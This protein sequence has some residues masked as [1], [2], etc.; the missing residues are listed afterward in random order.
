MKL[1]K[2]IKPIIIILLIVIAF[3]FVFDNPF[4]QS[5]YD[6]WNEEITDTMY[7]DALNVIKGSSDYI[8]RYSY[9]SFLEEFQIQYGLED[10]DATLL[11]AAAT[12]NFDYQGN[13]AIDLEEAN[14]VNYQVSIDQAGLYYIYV[15]YYV[16][17]S[18]LNNLTISVKINDEIE[19]DDAQIVDVPLIWED[20]SKEFSLDTYGDESLPNQLRVLEWK[21]LPLYNNTYTTT[22]PLLFYFEEG[23][24]TITFENVISGAVLFGD[25]QVVSPKVVPSYEAYST[26]YVSENHPET[27]LNIDATEYVDKNS[28]Y[29]RLYSFQSP[30]VSPFDSIDKKLNVINGAAWYRSG[31]EVTYS[32]TVSETGLYHLNL[33]YLNDKD[34]FSVFRSIYIDGEIPFDAFESYEFKVTGQNTWANEV[35]GTDET[36]FD[37]YLEEGV[38]QIAFRVETDSLSEELRNIQL[39]VDHINAFALNILKITGVNIDADR[40]WQFTNYIPETE[41]YL[42]AYETI[43]KR[44]VVTLSKYSNQ[45]DL[46]ATLAYLKTAVSALEVIVEEPDKIPLYLDSLYSG[47]GSVTQMLG[48]SL[49]MISKQPLYL[50]GFTIYNDNELDSPNA[51]FIQKLGSGIR[52]FTASFTEKKY[53]TENNPEAVNIWVSRSLIYVDLMQK[54]ADKAFSGTDIQIKI[55]IMPDANKLILAN[56]ANQTPDVALGLPSYMPFDLAIRG[57]LQDLSEFSDFWEVASEFS[58]GAF[59]P[60]VL[61]D[62]VYAI[63]ETLEFHALAYRIDTMNALGLS[64]PSTWEDVIDMLPTLQRYGMNFFYPTSGGTS[65]KWFYQTSALIYQSGGSIYNEDGLSTSINSEQSYNGLKLL[66]DLYTTYSL[67]SYVA[68]F[69]NSFRYNTL[70]IGIIDFNTYLTLKNAAPELTG[71][72]ALALY[73]GIEDENGDVQRW[74][75]ANGTSAIMFKNEDTQKLS[76][77][78]EFMKWWL[79]T[80]TQTEFAFALQ[81]TYGPEYVWLSGNI[82]AVANSP[83][84]SA[85]KA[86]ILEQVTWLVDVPRTPGQYMLE[87]GLSD[88]WNTVTFDGTSIRVAID[89]QVLKINREITKKM[90]EFGYIDS[91]GNILV[92][93][94]IRDTAWILEQIENY[95]AE[96]GE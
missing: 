26:L 24:N 42:R 62:K 47:T 71:Q 13:K 28:S 16:K 21:T 23:N 33:H 39:L 83:I 43:I 89:D 79:S 77:S 61:E 84:D 50:D 17:E 70:P 40:K 4:L 75:I 52:T 93:Y 1:K 19:F 67:P 5:D 44:A 12:S 63:P 91:N 85:D 55:S 46:S 57:A 96:G 92:P 72:W 37:I 20:E 22:E 48:D 90:V 86:V 29:V 64:I 94:T 18:V 51:N 74:Y 7:E 25:L 80:E 34:E 58:P 87:R 56:A 65:L 59:I 35:L 31:Q 41:S 27:I 60:Y 3:V 30:S 49:T 54:M 45:S 88:I 53:I 11:G 38:H 36:P 8:T 66:S 14:I 10:Y 78:W 73:P 69:Y 32:F 95:F 2:F 15:D 76:D 68:S 81:S 6:S 9:I 82:E